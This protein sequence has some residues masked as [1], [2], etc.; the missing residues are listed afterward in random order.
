MGNGRNEIEVR[1]NNDLLLEG[2]D[3]ILGKNEI[4]ISIDV[5]VHCVLS[6]KNQNNIELQSIIWHLPEQIRRKAKE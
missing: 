2:K 5:R 3:R 4:R 1:S 6:Q